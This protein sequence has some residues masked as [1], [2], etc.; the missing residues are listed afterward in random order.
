MDKNAIC[1]FPPD[2][3]PHDPA[4]AT[5]VC[6][7]TKPELASNQTREQNPAERSQALLHDAQIVRRKRC[8]ES[9]FARMI[10]ATLLLVF[11]L[12]AV[13]VV[14]KIR[15]Y[16]G[17]KQ[18]GGHWSAGWSRL[19]LL[20]AS[21]SGEM[22]KRFIAVNNKYGECRF[23]HSGFANLSQN[24]RFATTGKTERR[25]TARSQLTSCQIT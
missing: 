16:Y 18:F 19:W 23:Q 17:L 10:P 25:A 4:I 11:A 8:L 22:N 6:Q 9:L 13:F 15:A 3:T 14:R 24:F 1:Q 21:R 5:P 12:L 7:T 20:K 2:F